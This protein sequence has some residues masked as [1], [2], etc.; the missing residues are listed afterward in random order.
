[1][2]VDMDQN[3][4]EKNS[5]ELITSRPYFTKKTVQAA[6][7]LLIGL[8]LKLNHKMPYS[9]FLRHNNKYKHSLMISFTLD[10]GLK[11]LNFGE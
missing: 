3:F 7:K 5:F 1:M 4:L 10:I 8:F 9:M 11:T 6:Q 2:G